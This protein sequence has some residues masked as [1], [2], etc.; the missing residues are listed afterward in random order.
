MRISPEM[1]VTQI[2][3]IIDV[4]AD[5]RHI[6]TADPGDYAIGQSINLPEGSRVEGYGA[7]FICDQALPIFVANTCVN[8]SGIE[9]AANKGGFATGIA[10]QLLRSEITDCT[11]WNTLRY[12]I[13]ASGQFTFIDHCFVGEAGPAVTTHTGIRMTNSNGIFISRSEFYC[14]QGSPGAIELVGGQHFVV[15]KCNIEK[16]R[17]QIGAIYL[18]GELIGSIV[19]CWIESNDPVAIATR[20]NTQMNQGNKIVDVRDNTIMAHGQQ[21]I[22]DNGA[23]SSIFLDRNY[24]N[25]NGAAIAADMTNVVCGTNWFEGQKK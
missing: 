14:S 17:P 12:G 2:Q 9:F 18:E 5:T 11:F 19:G 23:A 25:L 6:V 4:A 24:G 8:I 10:G 15:E 21:V 20:V 16:N 13:C 3:E 1:S 22:V 7:K